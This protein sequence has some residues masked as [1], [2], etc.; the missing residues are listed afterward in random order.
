MD[1]FVTGCNGFIG[2]NVC[3]ILSSEGY[4]VIGT[5]RG[6]QKTF[7]VDK[8][9]TADIGSPFMVA[10]V[11]K[12]ISHCDCIVHTAALMSN[13]DF[14]QN[15]IS[16]NCIGTLNILKIA[17]EL[18]CQKIINI[19]G[20]PIIGP[21]QKHPI[22]E[23]HPVNPTS[24]YHATKVMQ[25]YILNLSSKY[26]IIT[27]NI[28]VPSPIGIGMNP[29]TIL[30]IFIDRCLNNEPLK[31]IGNGSR[32]Q[33]Y[34]DVRDIAK[35][36]ALCVKSDFLEDVYIISS[37]NAISNL[38]LAK[39]CIQLS[40]STSPIVMSGTPDPQEGIV[41]DYSCKRARS[42]G[43]FPRYTLDDTIMEIIAEKR[44]RF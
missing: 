6:K 40:G 41:W 28:R 33:D 20:A 39:K 26:D 17:V 15:L 30:P 14:D 44:K 13:D 42:M 35:F 19:S 8:Y 31:I 23:T 37:E 5:G 32:M 10:E 38:E 43:F 36:I 21:P 4:R 34:I 7:D 24:L 9:I 29:K 22:D 11:K 27:T 2:H 18:H 12:Y 16:T 3:E 25:E 1:I